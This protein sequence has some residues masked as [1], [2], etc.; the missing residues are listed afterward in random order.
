MSVTNISYKYVLKKDVLNKLKDSN[1]I[2]NISVDTGIKFSTLKRQVS[3]NHEYLT[4][5]GVLHSISKHTGKSIT[6]LLKM[7]KQ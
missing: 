6:N 2:A 7:V 1:L 3:E 4:L 5:Y